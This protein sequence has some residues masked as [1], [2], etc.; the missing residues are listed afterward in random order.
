MLLTFRPPEGAK[1]RSFSLPGPRFAPVLPQWSRGT[2]GRHMRRMFERVWAPSSVRSWKIRRLALL[3]HPEHSVH[4][5][6]ELFTHLPSRT[7]ALPSGHYDFPQSLQICWSSRRG[8]TTPAP[9]PVRP[10]GAILC[11]SFPGA[12]VSLLVTRG[13]LRSS[14]HPCG[15]PRLL[16]GES[17]G[18]IPQIHPEPAHNTQANYGVAEELPFFS[19]SLAGFKDV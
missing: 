13:A 11:W 10:F 7:R 2:S 19:A 9:S 1:P 6:A 12:S 15:R 8:F 5:P 3:G 17:D 18:G 14:L 16:S 4:L